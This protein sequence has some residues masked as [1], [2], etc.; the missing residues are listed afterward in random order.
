MFELNGLDK[1]QRDL[2]T[3]Q[4]AFSVLDGELGL[5][6]FDPSDPES[7]ETAIISVEAMIDERVTIYMGNPFVGPI[8]EEMKE[9][10]R[11]AILDRAAEARLESAG[12]GDKD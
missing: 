6:N 1:L 4:E 3:A 8:I 2:E 11:Q 7:I 9:K 12:K 5:V 10:Y